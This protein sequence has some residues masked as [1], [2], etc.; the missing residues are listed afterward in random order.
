LARLQARAMHFRTIFNR[1]QGTHSV[2]RIGALWRAAVLAIILS[3]ESLVAANQTCADSAQL[4]MD[5]MDLDACRPA[6]VGANEKTILLKSLPAEGEITQLTASQ[7]RKLKELGPVLRIHGREGVYELKV[8]ALPQA[9]T[10]LYG[11]AAILISLPALRLL[12]SEELQ[13]VVAHE[14]GHEY[15][16][17]EYARAQI[18][19]DTAC[20]RELELACDAIAVLTLVR[21][22][23]KPDRLVTATE[24]EFRFNSDRFGR[25]QNENSYPS[26]KARRDFV[27]RISRGLR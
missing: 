1:D 20:L 7:R 18:R 10:G 12:N 6:P 22:G 2:V 26:L 16:W 15:V 21:L 9:W 17:Q 4:V 8:I 3:S 19:N 24:K 23:V 13:A 5:V 14:I 11:R 27:K 25:S